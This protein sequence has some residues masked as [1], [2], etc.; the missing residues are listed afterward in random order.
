MRIRAVAVAVF[1]LIMPFPHSG[2]VEARSHEL[3]RSDGAVVP[4]RIYG[5]REGCPQTMIVSHGLGGSEA[6]LEGFA[7]ALAGQGWLVF[8]LGH[9]E[10]GRTVF[11]EALFSGAMRERLSA[12]AVDPQLYRARFADLEAA[13][14]YAT[15]RCR[16]PVLALAGHSMGAATVMLEAG[17]VGRMGRFGGDRF[18]VYVA[19]SPQGIGHMWDAGAWRAV[20]KPV[21]MV[22][23]TNDSGVDGDYETRLSAFEGLPPGRKRLAIIPGA[24]HIALG[25]DGRL[26]RLIAALSVEFIDALSGPGRPSLSRV[27]RVEVRDR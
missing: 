18:D 15:A 5:S 24:R 8:V 7:T 16:P 20:R 14:D 2:Q 23:G 17:A 21:L 19:I 3:R 26:G 25:R 12:A 13:F 27:T 1:C 10:S 22:T 11:R 9:R 4:A 6:A